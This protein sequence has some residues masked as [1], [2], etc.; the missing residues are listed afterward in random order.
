M[1]SVDS[2]PYYIE[3]MMKVFASKTGTIHMSGGHH[4]YG[5]CDNINICC[6]PVKEIDKYQFCKLCLHPTSNRY[7]LAKA[8]LN[9][10]INK[11][12][13]LPKLVAKKSKPIFEQVL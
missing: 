11:K 7:K 12:L 2:I 9:H 1:I 6:L 8:Y 10:V 13:Y 3:G 5:N 4:R